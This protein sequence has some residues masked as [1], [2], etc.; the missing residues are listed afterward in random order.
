MVRAPAN[1]VEAFTKKAYEHGFP[2]PYGKPGDRLWVRESFL[3]G[4]P[5][6]DAGDLQQFDDAGNELPRKAWY[7]A[8]QEEL[9]WLADDGYSTAEPRWKPSIHM[10]R[11]AC[12]ILLEVTEVRVEPLQAITEEDAIKEGF[13]PGLR[14]ST[15]SSVFRP[16]D[17][18]V[19]Q[20][21]A[22]CLFAFGSQ[23]NGATLPL[24]IESA[25]MGR[26]L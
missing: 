22:R 15:T 4:W 7:R 5:L 1:D 16:S 12:R 23:I 21:T 18:A 19:R 11:W 14:P 20:D 25:R 3:T 26:D 9:R 10:L 2:C 13:G 24:G 6:N 8:D 17:D